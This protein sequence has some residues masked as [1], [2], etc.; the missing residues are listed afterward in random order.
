MIDPSHLIIGLLPRVLQEVGVDGI[1]VVAVLELAPE[2][3]AHLVGEVVH[4][5][6]RI[7]AAGPHAQH[8]LVAIDYRFKELPDSL[9]CNSWPEGI[10]RDEVASLSVELV[11]VNL[12]VPWTMLAILQS[13]KRN[14][15]YSC[16]LVRCPALVAR[17]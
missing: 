4:E 5:V 9:W 15:T 16:C 10:R 14:Y 17:L 8:V 7:G 1:Q 11:A 6:R 3:D 13:W 12:E 2:Q